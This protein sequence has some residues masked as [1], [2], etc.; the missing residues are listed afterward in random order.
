MPTSQRDL[1]NRI[2]RLELG[3]REGRGTPLPDFV[4][5]CLPE[6]EADRLIDAGARIVSVHDLV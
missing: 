4:L 5:E 6:V 3:D 1:L 2:E